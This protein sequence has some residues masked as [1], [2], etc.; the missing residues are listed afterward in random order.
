MICLLIIGGIKLKNAILTNENT[1][2]LVLSAPIIALFLSKS[3]K[4]W[5]NAN[6]G[7]KKPY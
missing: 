2:Q 4:N 5:L 7:L 3:D 6:A 1:S